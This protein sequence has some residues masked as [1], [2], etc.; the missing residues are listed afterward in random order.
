M[1]GTPK[2][3]N[4]TLPKTAAKALLYPVIASGELPLIFNIFSTHLSINGVIWFGT[5]IQIHRKHQAAASL[6]AWHGWTS[7]ARVVSIKS[8]MFEYYINLTIGNIN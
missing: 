8:K 4:L 5:A 2:G 1:C 3:D 7:T 6:A